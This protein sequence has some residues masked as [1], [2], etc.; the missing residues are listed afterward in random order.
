[1]AD[2]GRAQ[3][4]RAFVRRM[5]REKQPDF[6]AALELAER[7]LPCPLCRGTAAI[8]Q[9][10]VIKARPRHAVSAT[11]CSTL[12]CNSGPLTARRRWHE[13]LA[14]SYRE[15]V[16]DQVSAEEA[17]VS[18]PRLSIYRCLLSRI[19]AEP[20]AAL[21]VSSNPFNIIG[22]S[23]GGFAPHGAG[24]SRPRSSTQGVTSRP[25]DRE[26]WRSG[27]PSAAGAQALAGAIGNIAR[28]AFWSGELGGVTAQARRN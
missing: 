22:A 10:K 18:K 1:M 21:L 17:G 6:A 12:R 9:P 19:K 4:N 23:A 26:P 3:E 15:F 28:K 8:R 13:D 24:A 25:P 11:R 7:D 2:A 16:D 20:S 14:S 5:L 27:R